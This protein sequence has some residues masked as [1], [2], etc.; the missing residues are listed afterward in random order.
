MFKLLIARIPASAGKQT[1]RSVQGRVAIWQK[2]GLD[3]Q[4]MGFDVARVEGLLCIRVLSFP[5]GALVIPVWTRE[6]GTDVVNGI[7]NKTTRLC[8]PAAGPAILDPRFGNP[9]LEL[10][11]CSF[12]AGTV[13]DIPAIP[14]VHSGKWN[15][16][17]AHSCKNI[18]LPTKSPNYIYTPST[19]IFL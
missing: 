6:G 17:P 9:F 8:I 11:F 16:I 4:A 19:W 13:L 5:S 14:G 7:V 10:E 15:S 2:D 12:C 3:L 18:P 1:L